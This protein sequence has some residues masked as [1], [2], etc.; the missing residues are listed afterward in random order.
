ML[1]TDLGWSTND[2][3]KQIRHKARFGSIWLPQLEQYSNQKIVPDRTFVAPDNIV[4][5]AEYR[6][7]IIH[8]INSEYIAL[9]HQHSTTHSLFCIISYCI[10]AQN[11][12]DATRSASVLAHATLCQDCQGIQ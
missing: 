12:L 6:N 2:T 10:F 11:S 3:T 4:H 1:M 9:F 5:R 7:A 8:A